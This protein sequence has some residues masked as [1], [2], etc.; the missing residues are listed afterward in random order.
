MP[1]AAKS[2]VP[3]MMTSAT[4]AD[5]SMVFVPAPFAADASME[6]ADAGCSLVVLITEGIPTLDM[7]KARQYLDEKGPYH[8]LIFLVDEVGQFIGGDSHLMLNLQ[9][10]TEDLGTMC[11]GRAFEADAAYAWPTAEICAMSIEGAV[12]VAAWRRERGV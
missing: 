1:S 12:D 5:V 11:G 10:I 2:P 9:T 7:V 3:K 8:R 4:G 6:A